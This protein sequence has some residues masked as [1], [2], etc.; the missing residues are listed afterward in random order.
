MRREGDSAGQVKGRLVEMESGCS[1]AWA[2]SLSAGD[3]LR[4]WLYSVRIDGR[5]ICRLT[6]PGRWAALDELVKTSKR[7]TLVIAHRLSTIRSAD[8]IAVVGDGRVV[9]QGTHVELLGEGG[10][11]ARLVEQNLA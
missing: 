4:C 3:L 11:Y 6:S 10:Q 7:T 2:G 9:E 5:R 8:M 1:T